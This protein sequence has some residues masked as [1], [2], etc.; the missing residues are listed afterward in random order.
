M[1]PRS[2]LRWGACFVLALGIHAAGAAA[3]LAHWHEDSD[4]VANAPVIMIE[5]AAR[6]RLGRI[7]LGAFEPGD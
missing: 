4:L 1:K 6:L 7:A 2:S 5:L 3:L